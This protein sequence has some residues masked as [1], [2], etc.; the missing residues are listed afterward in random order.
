MKKLFGLTVVLALVAAPAFANVFEADFEAETVGTPF[1]PS[2][3]GWTSAWDDNTSIVA[4]GLGGSAQAVRHSSDGTEYGGFELMSP[5]WTNTFGMISADLKITSDD[6]LYQFVPSGTDYYNT[7]I[8]FN[9]DGSIEVAQV[10]AAGDAFE[11]IATGATFPEA[12]EFN[13]AVE[14][15]ANGTL[16]A[17]LNGSPIFTGLDT[18]FALEGAADGIEQVL[19]FSDNYSYGTLDMD[20][21]VMTPEPATLALLAIGGV[22]AIRRRR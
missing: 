21:V 2:A 18:T 3:S 22:V 5:V 8:N 14:V 11:F 4:P 10:N 12:M 19:I 7:R 20:N 6:C 13:F 17:Y 1:T 9:P 15:L 16:T